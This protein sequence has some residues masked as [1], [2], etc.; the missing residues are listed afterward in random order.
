M[1]LQIRAHVN[2]C[3]QVWSLASIALSAFVALSNYKTQVYGRGFER[4]NLAGKVF[5]VTGANTGIGFQ[6]ARH[7]LSM[8]ATVVMACRLTILH[9]YR[10]KFSIN[11]I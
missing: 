1:C 4:V 8:G 11:I 10:Y 6:T 5:I 7:L 3:N 2:L 9:Y